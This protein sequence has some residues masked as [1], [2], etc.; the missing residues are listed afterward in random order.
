MVY[1]Y[2]K[3]DCHLA[4]HAMCLN[5]INK[6][7]LAGTHPSNRGDFSIIGIVPARMLSQACRD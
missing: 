6:P 4:A 2:P 1:H 5:K 3:V 7:Y